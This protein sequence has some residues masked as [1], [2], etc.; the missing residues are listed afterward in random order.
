[1]GRIVLDIDY[2]NFKSEVA[3]R[4]GY[5]REQVYHEVWESAVGAPTREAD[6]AE[7]GGLG[8]D[9]ASLRGRLRFIPIFQRLC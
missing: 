3:Q 8:H 1:M 9:A 7:I 4:M 2:A 6:G 5:A